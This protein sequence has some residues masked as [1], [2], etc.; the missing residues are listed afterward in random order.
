MRRK[1]T[2]VLSLF[3]LLL[4][5]LHV[6]FNSV[7]VE[8]PNGYRVHNLD[9]GLNYTTIQAAIDANETLD[10]HTIFVEVGVYY[11]SVFVSKNLTLIGENRDTTIID[12]N[13]TGDVVQL[14]TNANVTN[15]TIRNGEYGVIALH[16][17]IEAT[18][19]TTAK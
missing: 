2:F 14:G 11:E 6:R 17:C 5:L 15:F 16:L 4:S 13:G 9:T 18:L 8:A 3:V 7:K 10:G 19:S 12:G 1:L